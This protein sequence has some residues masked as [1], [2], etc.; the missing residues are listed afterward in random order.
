MQY[1]DLRSDTV[2]KPSD[3][4][5]TAM[6]EAVVGDDV[7]GDDPTMNTLQERVAEMTGKEAALFTCSGTQANVCA[8]LAHTYPG[9]EVIVERDGHTFKYEVAAPSVIGGVQLNTLAGTRGI[10]EAEQIESAIRPDD[11]HQAPTRLIVLENTHNRGGGKIYPLDKI[12]SIAKLAKAHDIKMHLDGARLFN[13]SIATDIPVDTYASYFDSIMFCF[14]KGLGT[15]VGSIIAGSKK[16]IKRAHRFRKM[17]GGG[18]RQVGILAA[19]CHYALDHNVERLADDHKNAKKLASGL[20]EIDGFSV[21]PESIETNI[22]IFDVAE[23]GRSVSDVVH[24]FKERNILLVP[25][26]PTLIRAVTHLDISGNDIDETIEIAK[27][28]FA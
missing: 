25:F 18:M 21:D 6:A 23:S 17:M 10:L 28:L 24:K 20:S 12:E 3:G 26:G 16:F 13:A 1:I 9:D 15:P 5:R 14:S 8:I 2:T 11:V 4:M 27:K 7:F 19:A 22:V